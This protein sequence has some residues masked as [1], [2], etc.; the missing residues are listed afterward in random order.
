MNKQLQE[1]N[2]TQ[3]T[4]PSLMTL[5]GTCFDGRDC[6]ACDGWETLH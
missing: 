2:G 3:Q 5:M 6:D 4:I 1:A